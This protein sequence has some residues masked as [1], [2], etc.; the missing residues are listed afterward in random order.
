[1]TLITWQC[2]RCGYRTEQR[3]AVTGM[4]HRCQPPGRP[5]KTIDLHRTEEPT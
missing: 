1:M 3:P 5:A 4:S 2:R